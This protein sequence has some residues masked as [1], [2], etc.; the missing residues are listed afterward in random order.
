MSSVAAAKRIAGRICQS[1]LRDQRRPVARA[2]QCRGKG[3]WFGRG[4]GFAQVVVDVRNAQAG[5]DA[6][7]G[8]VSEPLR[9]I[10]SQARL[11]L[12]G[13]RETRM[14]ALGRTGDVRAAAPDEECLPETGPWRDDG[15]RTV[16]LRPAEIDGMQVRRPEMRH[17]IGDRLQVVQQHHALQAEALAQG[18]LPR[19]P[20][21]DL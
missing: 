18:A 20:R 3:R 21:A 14:A 6:F 2:R 1:G 17:G 10:L 19:D 7:A 16:L 9:Q 4:I 5:T 11:P 15:N 8:H 13:G 12:V